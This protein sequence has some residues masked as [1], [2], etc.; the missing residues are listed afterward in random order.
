MR[1]VGLRFVGAC[2]LVG[3]LTA[4]AGCGGATPTMAGGK[5]VAHWVEQMRSPDARA[6]K[7][8][9]EKLGNVGPAD[10]AALP[11]V[12]AALKDVDAAVR[13]AAVL[14]LMK[15]GPEARQAADTLAELRQR[16]RSPQ[17]RDYAARALKKIA[18]EGG[19]R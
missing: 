14:A 18:D 3:M 19:V 16:D 17:V 9:V 10:P 8:A 12:L 15:F 1:Q 13:G 2:G 7:R 6:R 5:P 11:A 4:L